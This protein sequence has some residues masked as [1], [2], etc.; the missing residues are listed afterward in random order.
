MKPMEDTKPYPLSLAEWKEI[1]EVPVIR[2]SWGFDGHEQ[3]TEFAAQVYAAKFK[4]VSGSPGYVGDLFILQGDTLTGDAPFV[5]QRGGDGT[6]V[7]L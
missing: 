2:E 4:F 7:V 1:M 6:L 5:L 3:P